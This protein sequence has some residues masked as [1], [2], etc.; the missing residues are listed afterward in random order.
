MTMFLD[1]VANGKHN[2]V[3]DPPQGSVLTL[4]S[5]G[6]QKERTPF[7]PAFTCLNL[8]EFIFVF[9]PTAMSRCIKVEALIF[10]NA[11]GDV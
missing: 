5:T 9:P 4:D 2:L 3:Q 7:F 10:L 8:N 6:H 11:W 1:S